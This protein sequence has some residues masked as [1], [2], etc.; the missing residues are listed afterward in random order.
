[1]DFESSLP[2]QTGEKKASKVLKSRAGLVATAKLFESLR[3]AGCIPVFVLAEKRYCIAA[4]M[5]ETF[6]DS[7]YNDS[8]DTSELWDTIGREDIAEIFYDLPYDKLVAFAKAYREVDLKTLTLSAQDVA[9]WLAGTSHEALSPK[10]LDSLPHLS[11]MCLHAE[12]SH[13]W[14][15]NGGVKALNTPVLINLFSMV[16]G[17]GIR[18][19]T[20]TDMIHD[21]TPYQAALEKVFKQYKKAVR[22]QISL[23]NGIA[24]FGYR[25]LTSLRFARSAT[26]PLLRAA[27]FLSGFN[28]Q[29]RL[30][31][32][33]EDRPNTEPL[34]AIL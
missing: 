22:T 15:P 33:E 4:K 16:E 9:A 7:E 34:G 26:T 29:I 8:V 13:V 10:I 25:H 6:L 30:V 12:H 31:L 14:L 19:Q 17:Y 3:G 21:D 5:V 1:M 20:R 2:Q 32:R 28:Q 18:T 11:E 23:P 27:D 24:Y